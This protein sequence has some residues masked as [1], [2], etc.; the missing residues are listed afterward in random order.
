M[1]TLVSEITVSEST[2]RDRRQLHNFRGTYG[3]VDKYENGKLSLSFGQE[4]TL[5][6]TKLI[7]LYFPKPTLITFTVNST[8]LSFEVKGVV[9]LPTA[10]RIHVEH[11]DVDQTD[12]IEFSYTKA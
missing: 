10:G 8:P 6:F 12:P 2:T 9:H 11:D 4:A 7:F 3:D 1:T 5:D